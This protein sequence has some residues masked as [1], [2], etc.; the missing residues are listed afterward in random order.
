MSSHIEIM[1]LAESVAKQSVCKRAQVGAVV[2][3]KSGKQYT[4][5]NLNAHNPCA[6]CEGE[7]GRTLP[8]VIHA[9]DHALGFVDEDDG[10]VIYV[11][12]QPC[13]N[14]SELIVEAGV[15]KV[16]YRDPD[17]KTDG[18]EYLRANSVQ[19]DSLWI[20]G[21]ISRYVPQDLAA[22]QRVWGGRN[23]GAT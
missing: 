14:C 1:R 12:R 15:S 2:I 4:G 3:T 9:E 22:V 23:G 11:T 13:I 7:D 17:D 18:L 21:Q 6:A 19:V 20:S 16:Y 8:D 5:F 10:E